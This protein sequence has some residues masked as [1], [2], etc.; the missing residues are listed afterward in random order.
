VPNFQVDE[1][2]VLTKRD[3]HVIIQLNF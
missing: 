3:S 2:I 1:E